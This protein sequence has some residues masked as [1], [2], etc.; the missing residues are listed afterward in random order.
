MNRNFLWTAPVVTFALLLAQAVVGNDRMRIPEPKQ[1]PPATER[2]QGSG[3]ILLRAIIDTSVDESARGP[4]LL[5]VDPVSGK[6]SKVCDVDADGGCWPRVSP[7]GETVVFT[8]QMQTEIWNCAANGSGTA[9]RIAEVG[10]RPLWSADGKRILLTRE[11]HTKEKGFTFETLALNSDGSRW[12]DD[13]PVVPNEFAVR[14]V[15]ADGRNLLV[16]SVAERLGPPSR[17]SV[18]R[19]DGTGRCAVP[20]EL[21]KGSMVREGRFSPDGLRV[22]YV[23]VGSGGDAIWVAGR[24][25]SNSM[26]VID[27]KPHSVSGLCWSPDG[28]ELAVVTIDVSRLVPTPPKTAV[29]LADLRF[30]LS[31]VSVKEGK[32]REVR[33]VNGTVVHLAYP[34]WVAPPSK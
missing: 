23:L 6:W 1:N 15:S 33:F 7:D 14:D 25:G 13:K 29:P 18:L 26:K 22:V 17:L 19:A 8:N 20:K 28:A 9:A 5:A 12:K 16:A 24:D 4:V 31:V 3:R 30:G 32:A 11:T 27:L 34:E 2:A 10:G 21:P